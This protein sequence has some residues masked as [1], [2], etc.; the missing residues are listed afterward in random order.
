L[1]AFINSITF[2]YK[3]IKL[4]ENYY[5]TYFNFTKFSSAALYKKNVKFL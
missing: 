2:T 4:N 5:G 1:T 3:V